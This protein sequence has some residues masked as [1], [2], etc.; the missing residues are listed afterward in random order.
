MW[1][2]FPQTSSSNLNNNLYLPAPATAAPGIQG[3]GSGHPQSPGS[4][5]APRSPSRAPADARGPE[6]LSPGERARGRGMGA[7]SAPRCPAAR[8]PALPSPGPPP[9]PAPVPRLP[10]GRVAPRYLGSDPAGRSPRR[11]HS[12]LCETDTQPQLE[13]I[14]GRSAP[15]ARL[16]SPNLRPGAKASAAAGGWHRVRRA[17]AASG[18]FTSYSEVLQ[19][20]AAADRRHIDGFQSQHRKPRPIAREPLPLPARR[21]RPP[22]QSAPAPRHGGSP[23]GAEQ[24]GADPGW[25]ATPARGHWQGVGAQAWWEAPFPRG[26][27]ID[28][29][30]DSGARAAEAG[31]TGGPPAGPPR[32]TPPSLRFLTHRLKLL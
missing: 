24:R 17:R 2:L 28:V 5:A 6:G 7:G 31:D 11:C 26:I 3:P 18:G 21:S 16:A 32:C 19:R 1:S 30:R 9:R 8:V 14:A 27:P 23:A 29:A 10:C 13:T 4:L 15:D 20:A 25:D 22:R 12:A